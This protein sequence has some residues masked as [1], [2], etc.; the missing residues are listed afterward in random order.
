MSILQIIL[1][2]IGAVILVIL[3]SA[4]FTSAE[5]TVQ[6]EIIIDK[7]LPAVFDYVKFSINQNYYN[8]WWMMDPNARKEYSGTDAEPGFIMKWES[9]NKQAGKGEQEIKKVV[10]NKRVDYEIRFIK[11][12]QGVAA[13]FMETNA[14]PGNQ[15]RVV[16]AFI[17]K[18][19]FG[20][21]IFHL[22]F[23]L[24][25]MLGSDIQISLT[26]LKAVL[27]KQ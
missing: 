6:K 10:E 2:V 14:V 23:N 12:F 1:I 25:K 8:K 24:K 16:W 4:A 7:P 27:E 15:T 5:Y 18:R 22:L 21:R 9:D 20:M 17:G 13:S 11:P 3:L 26:N 19:N